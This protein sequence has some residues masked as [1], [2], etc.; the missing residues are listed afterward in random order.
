MLEEFPEMALLMPSTSVYK[1][2]LRFWPVRGFDRWCI[3][4]TFDAD[5]VLI[6]RSLHRSRDVESILEE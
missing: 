2:A 5:E 1:E 4:C 3:F 6:V